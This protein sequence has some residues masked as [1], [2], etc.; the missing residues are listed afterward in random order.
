MSANDVMVDLETL[1]VRTT[2][3]VLSIGATDGM[4]NVWYHK[5]GPQIIQQQINDGRTI[6][7]SSLCW[8]MDQNQ[9]ARNEAFSTLPD[10]MSVGEAL[11][12]FLGW[13]PPD[14]K[15]WGYGAAFDNAILRSLHEQYDV[16]C[17]DFHADRCYRTMRS[18]APPG[19]TRTVPV[20]AHNALSDAE[21]Q[22]MDLKRIQQWL[23]RP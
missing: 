23:A 6:D 22:M 13:L 7:F 15:I 12:V 1:G 17:W 9:E 5:F 3:V 14:V 10:N 2:S 4:G 20:V 11:H 18:L 21:A 19:F 16:P 8:W